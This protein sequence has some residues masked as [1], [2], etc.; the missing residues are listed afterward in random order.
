MRTS[1]RQVF[2]CAAALA[3]CASG[4]SGPGARAALGGRDAL[5][6]RVRSAGALT[7]DRVLAHISHTCDLRIGATAYPVVDLR[8]LVPAAMS[9]RGVNA[10]LVFAPN[11]E[12]LLHKIEYTNERPLLCVHD[13]LFL[14]GDLRV[15]VD[16]TTS[17]GNELTFSEGARTFTAR[18]V[19]PKDVPNRG[20]NDPVQ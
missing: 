19:E 8:E 9:P 2:V 10:I 15:E 11:A 7:P 12:R 20:P 16:G 6:A 4:S 18:H 5:V 1:L 13:R 3:G 14:W 17:E